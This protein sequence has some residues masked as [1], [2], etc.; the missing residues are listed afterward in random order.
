MEPRSDMQQL[1]EDNASGSIVP[2]EHNGTP[3]CSDSDSNEA[4]HSNTKMLEAELKTNLRMIYTLV[5]E[6]VD[7]Q[8]ID[9]VLQQRLGTL[10]TL[11]GDESSGSADSKDGTSQHES[12]TAIDK[13]S[14][15]VEQDELENMD[16]ANIRAEFVTQS[17]KLLVKLE[18]ILLASIKDR[19]L[20]DPTNDKELLGLMDQR[21][22]H[23]MLEII[24]CWGIYPC[25]LPGVGMP[26][27]RRVRSNIVQK[28]LFAPGPGS[29]PSGS[30]STAIKDTV[31]DQIKQTNL[32][33]SII[34]PL[35]R[36][37]VA[38]TPKLTRFTTLGSILTS[39][40]V[41]DLYAALLQLAYR[42]LSKP[43]EAST[44]AQQAEGPNQGT[45]SSNKP[46]K[47]TPGSLLSNK[48]RPSP[49]DLATTPL[50]E[51]TLQQRTLAE[52]SD[53]PDRSLQLQQK[54]ES[55]KLFHNLFWNTEAA[56][57]LES[58]T[59]L[60]SSSSPMHPTPAWLKSVS[61]RFLSQI[62]L[63]PGGVRVVLEY[64]QGGADT[65]KLGQLERVARLVTSVPDQMS[66]VQDYYRTICPELLEILEMDLKLVDPDQDKTKMTEQQSRITPPSP[67][68][69]QTTTFV[70]SKLLAKSPAICQVEIVA[71]EV[72][73]LWKWGTKANRKAP[74]AKDTIPRNG[75]SLKQP[76]V[77]D[78]TGEDMDDVAS[79]LD[80]LVASE[81][82]VTK[83]VMFL[84]SFLVGNEPSPLL[85]QAFLGQAAQGLY[86]LYEFSAQ[87]RS[88]LRE[89]AKEILVVYF[90]ILDSADTV[91]IL[92]AIVMRRRVPVPN[93]KPWQDLV[94]HEGR[95]IPDLIEMGA[96][97]ESY[98]APGPTGGAV[99]RRR[100]VQDRNAATQLELDVDM[101]MD[102][103]G[104][105]D[106]TGRD[107]EI[108][109]DLYMYLL[110]EYQAGKA[111]G[112]NAVLPRR[113]LTMLQLILSMT[114]KLGPSIMTKVTQ[115]IGL[116][117]NILEHQVVIEGTDGSEAVA[118]E[119]P[120]EADME[121][122]GLV[123]TLLSAILTENEHLSQQD[124][125]L[126]SLTLIHLKQLVNH[127]LIEIRRVAHDL[128]TLIPTRLSDSSSTNANAPQKTEMEVEMEKYASAL[129]ALQ[130]SLLP[131]RA[132]GLHIL[133]EMI[134]SKSI[135][136][137]RSS[138]GAGAER[139]LDHALDIFV[140]HVQEPDSFIYLN[141]VKGL[142]ALTDA[143]GP[144]ILRKL[145]RIYANEDGRQTLDT[146]L[147]IGEALVQTVQRCG[148]ALGGYLDALLPGLYKVM[149]TAVDKKIMEAR[150]EERKD[151][152]EKVK[153]ERASEA[154]LTPEERQRKWRAER[155]RR[156]ASNQ[157]VGQENKEEEE[158]EDQIV[159]EVSLLRSSALTILA[160]AAEN[161]PTG[162]L[163]EM[164]YLVDWVLSILDL[165]R[166]TEVRRAAT[167]VMVLLFRALGGNSLYKIE[168]DQLKRVYR[169]LRYVEQV[170]EDPLCR[171]QARAGIA[172]LDAIV[173]MEM[174]AEGNHGRSRGVGVGSL[175]GIGTTE[176]RYK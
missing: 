23:T 156:K 113:M 29:A 174:S 61:G 168:G 37:T 141:A 162:L 116:A 5:G 109:G 78:T 102:F 40:H 170:D 146:R 164:R 173:R 97:G 70:L 83:A 53:A 31:V 42:P 122:L 20:Y 99:L 157:G 172:D 104:E 165:D 160:T 25:L 115:I 139:E 4:G 138:G 148:E 93:S 62:L 145:M 75:G 125:H 158:G 91:E 92:K 176:V 58:L 63:R 54:E 46:R 50:K 105:L 94:T 32:L 64:M 67:Q 79:G 60:L 13:D 57:S 66:S 77:V 51:T 149:N 133:R 127:P 131:V 129:A 56:K 167:L 123:L 150:E 45:S 121:I 76:S 33:W 169:T 151:L 153:L 143:H 119:D 16:N 90:R 155:E 36:I 103:L 9:Q 111:R 28:E 171:A 120:E 112:G 98:Y 35:G 118:D 47:T 144:E 52:A 2:Q 110:D 86:Q 22:I 85:F 10:A 39:R 147:R 117:N 152:I 19:E 74:V 175:A 15:D 107:G 26:L 81:Y 1:K 68:L 135:V 161:C 8:N 12:E 128:Q 18:E 159:D 27:S 3:S 71:K 69:V 49:G 142:A 166:Q 154:L 130:D 73:P 38:Y 126:L 55:A 132:H 21:M 24:V 100:S 136:L 106:T 89:K 137:T 82:E 34:G 96:V 17:V 30:I 72:G 114:Q 134:L 6:R 108:L 59:T 84:H 95:R 124:R 43:K 65:V 163:P 87:V 101:F 80:P 88:V 41:P 140:Q 44:S 11:R 14:K 48:S 7:M